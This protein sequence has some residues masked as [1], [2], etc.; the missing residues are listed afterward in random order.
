M[1]WLILRGLVREQRHW[2]NFK[3][4]LSERTQ[5]NVFALDL[6][7]MGTEVNRS[8]PRTIHGIMSDIHDRFVILRDSN[9]DKE[10]GIC[11]VSLG[12]MVALQ[13]ISEYPLDFKYAV[14]TNSSCKPLSPLLK[15][16]KPGNILKIPEFLTSTNEY[17]REK[18]ILGMTSSMKSQTELNEIAGEY[19]KFSPH[20]PQ[21]IKTGL[22]H[23]IAGSTFIIPK[24]LENSNAKPVQFLIINS[25]HDTLVDSSCS[26]IIAKYLNASIRTH[27]H[28]NHDL[29]LDDPEWFANTIATWH[30]SIKKTS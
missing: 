11:C 15:R 9:P 4:L 12:S 30:K 21:F 5:S 28:A 24:N 25:L 16:F 19:A 13:W 20:L 22:A 23:L 8:S 3:P 2:R 27:D 14:I 29:S 1:N 7:G 17:K 6:P 18:M 26:T 10:W